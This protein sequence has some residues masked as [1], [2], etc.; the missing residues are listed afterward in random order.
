MA[1]WVLT[2]VPNSFNGEKR[3]SSTDGAETTGYAHAKEWN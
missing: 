2:S 3:V 1:N